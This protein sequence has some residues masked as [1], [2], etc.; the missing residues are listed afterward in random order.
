MPE[1]CGP[2]GAYD[3]SSAS[4]H[5]ARA[6]DRVELA[7][8]RQVAA[9]DELDAAEA[10]GRDGRHP[11]QA[12]AEEVPAGG[13]RHQPRALRSPRT[14]IRAAWAATA[15]ASTRKAMI[16]ALVAPTLIPT[17]SPGSSRTFSVIQTP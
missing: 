16:V 15:S 4:G 14:A 12:V 9:A 17:G 7:L 8:A 10:D 3:A 6:V 13:E 2:G 11:G 5:R 1:T